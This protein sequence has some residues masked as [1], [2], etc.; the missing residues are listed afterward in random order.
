MAR[1]L[2]TG[3]QAGIVAPIAYP[4]LFIE[5]QFASGTLYLWTGIG[6]IAWN[7]QNWIGVGDALAVQPMPENALLKA[8]GI[9]ISL[10][11]IPSGNLSDILN[12]IQHG[13]TC[14]VWF[15]LLAAPA[16]NGAP[17]IVADPYTSFYGRIDTGKIADSG[18]NIQA[19][20]TVETR[21]FDFQRSQ[22]RRYTTQ[23]QA[24]DFPSDTGFDY[25]PAIQLWNGVWGAPTAKSGLP[26]S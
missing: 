3:M 15:G 18:E 13:L 19:S 2:T 23:D 10:N 20:I 24:I 16:T 1:D 26:Q 9:E 6:T 5:A 17:Q 12:E 4:V 11:S 22:E 14:T 7:S 8:E 25:V 21:L